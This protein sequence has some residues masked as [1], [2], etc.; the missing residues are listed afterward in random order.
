MQIAAES[1]TYQW[2]SDGI[3][4]C[5]NLRTLCT[6]TL[7]TSPPL[8]VFLR[9][10]KFF[11]DER[12][13]VAFLASYWPAPQ[14]AL[15]MAAKSLGI[16]T[17]MMSDSHAGT[18]RAAGLKKRL[19]RRIVRMFDAALVAGSPHQ[20]YYASLGI[21]VERIFTG[22]DVVDNRFFSESSAR[23]RHL[24]TSRET[25]GAHEIRTKLRLPDRYFLN[26]GRMVEKKN[27][28]TLLDAFSQYVRNCTRNGEA[29]YS[30]VLVGSGECERTLRRKAR[31][32]G[33]NV[34]DCT[35][36]SVKEST[37]T[38]CNCSKTVEDGSE[39]AASDA[40]KAKA[41]SVL[42]YG[43]RQITETPFFY[44]FAEAFILP[45][46]SEEWGLVVNEAM[47]C[48]LPVIVSRTAGCAEDLLPPVGAGHRLTS[49]CRGAGVE[50]GHEGRGPRLEERANGF[51]F[52]PTSSD[53]LAEAMSLI[54]SASQEGHQDQRNAVISQ[55]KTQSLQIV[56]G[57]SCEYFARQTLR[58]AAASTENSS[59]R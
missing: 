29:A 23:A 37:V 34:I 25:C 46:L 20:R 40:H 42:F 12:I 14:L 55:M 38:S 24:A 13:G 31:T 18:E 58:A 56:A 28:S 8:Q 33:L 43:Y 17:V 27:L 50:L 19:K 26:I 22:F 59:D 52:D 51:L 11:R 57:F 1:S 41:G 30:L 4:L 45:S 9:A 7:E 53:A 21:P 49:P 10:R 48:S 16:P 39:Y 6:G 35:D 2:S 36:V 32:L 54:A 15:A 47:A 3:E 5:A 44:A